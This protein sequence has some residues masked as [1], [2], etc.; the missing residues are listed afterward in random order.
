MD[1]SSGWATTSRTFFFFNSPPK[2]P[3]P[4]S[5][6]TTIDMLLLHQME[7]CEIL[8]HHY[9]ENQILQMKKTSGGSCKVKQPRSGLQ[10]KEPEATSFKRTEIV[11]GCL[12]FYWKNTRGQRCPAVGVDREVEGSL[13]KVM[14][15]KLNSWFEFETIRMSTKPITC[16]QYKKWV[17]TATRVRPFSD[18]MDAEERIGLNVIS[19]YHKCRGCRC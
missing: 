17:F 2:I 13:E 6:S 4:K 8:T 11:R 3:K 16:S 7:K 14:I 15:P 18:S 5:E 19:F 10:R 9:L 1:S 12:I